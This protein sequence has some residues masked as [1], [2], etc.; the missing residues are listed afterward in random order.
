MYGVAY[1]SS[2]C[3]GG[4]GGMYG[5]ISGGA[6]LYPARDASSF[7]ALLITSVGL[8]SSLSRSGL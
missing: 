6:G 2:G 7:A 8:E 3:G 4:G 1:S 5:L